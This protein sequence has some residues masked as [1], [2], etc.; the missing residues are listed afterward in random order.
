MNFIKVEN[1]KEYEKL[2]SR[3]LVIVDYNTVWCGPCKK[4]APIFIE[5]S[6]KYPDTTFLSV[7]P[8]II[9]H[10]DCENIQTVP[11]FRVFI[12]GEK[13]REFAGIDRERLE[14]YI[15]RYQYQIFYNG[16]IVRTFSEEDKK[17]IVDYMNKYSE[18]NE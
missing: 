1:V 5:I 16:S 18:K 10:E 8:E 9:E 15:E 14:R 3:G 11:T 13:K 6:E 7:D 4:F 2:K 12:N 17:K